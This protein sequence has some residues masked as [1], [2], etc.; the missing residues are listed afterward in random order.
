MG[1]LIEAEVLLDQ[2]NQA[3]TYPGSAFAARADR[4]IATANGISECPG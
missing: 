1:D 4:A 3:A 2:L